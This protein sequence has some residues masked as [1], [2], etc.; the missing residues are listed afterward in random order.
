M[1]N[2]E[3]FPSWAFPDRKIASGLPTDNRALCTSLQVE[4][5]VD[6]EATAER[7]RVPLRK[8]SQVVR[9]WWH[10]GERGSFPLLTTLCGS[11]GLRCWCS[12]FTSFS[13]GSGSSADRCISL[14]NDSSSD[15]GVGADPKTGGNG[16]SDSRDA[17]MDFR[18]DRPLNEPFRTQMSGS[19]EGEIWGGCALVTITS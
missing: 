17:E 15:P 7:N 12:S 14:G 1:T 10:I 13:C 4:T 16:A 9:V 18:G 2:M 19:L 11:G 3:Y 6:P 8:L 5:S